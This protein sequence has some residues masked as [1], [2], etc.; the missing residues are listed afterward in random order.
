MKYI[1]IF[2]VLLISVSGH[3]DELKLE[4]RGKVVV[5][6]PLN[7]GVWNSKETFDTEKYF[8]KR[9]LPQQREATVVTLELPPGRYAIGVYVDG[10][11]N[12]VL[13]TN[14]VG[15]PKEMYGFSNDARNRFS[16][17]EWSKAS[18]D[19]G[20]GAVSQ[21]IHVRHHFD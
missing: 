3:A 18:F 4:I 11:Q 9:T 12:G 10:N 8:L 2:A 14:F 7:I 15:M 21:S 16:P 19:I 5:G 20:Y 17:P 6:Q 1:A 13:D